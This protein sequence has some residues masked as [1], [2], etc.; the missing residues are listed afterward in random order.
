MSV[1]GQTDYIIDTLNGLPGQLA[2]LSPASKVSAVN[3]DVVS[4]PAGIMV[5]YA[6]SPASDKVILPTASIGSA[7]GQIAGIVLHEHDVDTI[8][9]QTETTDLIFKVGAGMTLLQKGRV[10]VTPEVAVVQGD[11]V[12]YRITANGGNTQVG[13]FTN[14]DDGAHTDLLKGARFESSTDATSTQ[15]VLSFDLNAALV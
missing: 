15:A 11:P 6:S 12:Y 8:G 4:L 3:A 9:L 10:Y 1:T 5:A 13:A 7:G 2:D 14:T